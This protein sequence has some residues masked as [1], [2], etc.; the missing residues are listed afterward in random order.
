MDKKNNKEP[1]KYY[2]IK[3]VKE[4]LKRKEH[5]VYADNSIDEVIIKYEDIPDFIVD[6]NRRIGACDLKFYD[7]NNISL[8]PI[9]S[10]YGEFLNKCDIKVHEDIIDRLV[11]LQTNE[12]SIKDYKLIDEFTMET[13]RNQIEKNKKLKER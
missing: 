11:G 7:Y 1:F 12:Q 6:I 13:A 4:I 3:E 9:V 8:E 10:C 2:D 5:L